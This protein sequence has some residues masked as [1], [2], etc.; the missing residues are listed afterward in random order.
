MKYVGSRILQLLS[1]DMYNID[2]NALALDKKSS[3]ELLLI[4]L[5]NGQN[6]IKGNINNVYFLPRGD[7][8]TVRGGSLSMI[9]NDKALV[10]TIGTD[11]SAAIAN[12]TQERH[13]V[14]EELKTL[15]NDLARLD[16]QHT[17]LMRAW[18]SNKKSQMQNEKAIA[19]FAS[20]V[21][22]LRMELDCLDNVAVDTKVEEDDVADAETEIEQLKA[23]EAKVK[24][25]FDELSPRIED[26]RSRLAQ[27]SQRND[28]IYR[29]MTEAQARMTNLLETQT[30]QQGMVDRHKQ[31]LE[32]YEQLVAT[33]QGRVDEYNEER[34]GALFKARF[35]Q[36]QVTK[37]IA[38]ITEEGVPLSLSQTPGDEELE[39]IEPV[40]V[41]RDAD[42]YKAKVERAKKKIEHERQKQRLNDEDAEE[43]HDKYIQAKENLG[44]YYTTT[45]WGFAFVLTHTL[46]RPPSR[47]IQGV[48]S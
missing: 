37:M 23:E 9:S 1:V 43:A 29:D 30:Q 22:E 7:H 16:Q 40:P 35:L 26:I 27:T 48:K 33:Y 5:P 46:D 8:W 10:S 45:L 11:K 34:L 28:Q 47:R 36:H 17:A 19:D 6:K 24:G 32:Q 38:D 4:S 18:N 20:Q 21:E 3:E 25:E 12:A 13:R 2:Q 31:K 44:T 39:A 41:S 15:R 14:N 42:Y